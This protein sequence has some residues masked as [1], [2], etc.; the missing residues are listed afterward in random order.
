VHDT[1]AMH[2]SLQR[3]LTLP[4]RSALALTARTPPAQRTRCAWPAGAAHAH[5]RY[6]Q[7]C[8]APTE[9]RAA[10]LGLARRLGLVLV[11]VAAW[12]KLPRAVALGRLA[13]LALL[14]VAH[15][16]DLG[17]DR[18]A[19]AVVQLAVDLGQGVAC[20]RRRAPPWLVSPAHA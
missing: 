11:A 12:A 1:K 3:A 10:W 5:A 6:P 20:A 7:A 4:E 9:A 15:A 17:V 16:H 14:A 2:V 19:D 8:K 13:V 18:R